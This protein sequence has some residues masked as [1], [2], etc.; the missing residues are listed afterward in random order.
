M[1]NRSL[2]DILCHS[3]GDTF[4]TALTCSLRGAL[5]DTALGSI[6][7]YHPP[8]LVGET[9]AININDLVFLSFP[10]GAEHLPEVQWEQVAQHL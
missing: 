4:N 9:E 10:R 7:V 1:C 3:C 8:S 5:N 2:L 6:A